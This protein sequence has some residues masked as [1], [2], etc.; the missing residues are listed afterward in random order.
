M[1][2]FQ[3]WLLVIYFLKLL[4]S[5]LVRSIAKEKFSK[6]TFYWAAQSFK[7]HFVVFAAI[8]ILSLSFIET[9]VTWTKPTLASYSTLLSVIIWDFNIEVTDLKASAVRVN[10]C[11]SFSQDL[12]RLLFKKNCRLHFIFHL[13]FYCRTYRIWLYLCTWTIVLAFETHQV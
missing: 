3:R 2:A 10:K 4:H 13:K 5:F 12:E 1:F 6:R 11:K 8:N 9:S 7:V